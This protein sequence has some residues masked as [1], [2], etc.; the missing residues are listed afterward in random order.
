MLTKREKRLSILP[1]SQNLF[2]A[3]TL[4]SQKTGVDLL[5]TYQ[6]LRNAGL[7]AETEGFIVAAQD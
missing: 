5:D 7:K 2:M 3:N 1:G 4:L 6:Q